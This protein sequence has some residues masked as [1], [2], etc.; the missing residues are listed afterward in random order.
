MWLIAIWVLLC[1][2]LFQFSA[3]AQLVISPGSTPAQLISSFAGQGLTV[4]NLTIN[5]NGA[6]NGTAIVN[7]SGASGS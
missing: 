5:C 7:P 1:N 3:K 2:G 4:S 6:C